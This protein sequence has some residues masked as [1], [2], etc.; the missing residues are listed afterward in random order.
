MEQIGHVTVQMGEKIR[1]RWPDG[2]KLPRAVFFF[3]PG[4]G[5]GGGVGSPSEI[6]GHMQEV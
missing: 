1:R 4:G 2:H 5:G 3:L 6:R